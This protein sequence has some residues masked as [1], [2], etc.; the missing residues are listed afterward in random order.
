MGTRNIHKQVFKRLFIG[1]V[2]LSLII[3]GAVAY[4]EIRKADSL[5]LGLA[6]EESRFLTDEINRSS[7]SQMDAL[8]RRVDEFIKGHFVVIELY[9][10]NRNQILREI[11]PRRAAIEQKL[12]QHIR[13][14]PLENAVHY[15]NFFVE[16]RLFLHLL[17]PLHDEKGDLSGYFKGV[18]QVDSQTLHNIKADIAGTLLLVVVVIL[19]TAIMLYP[20]IISLNKGLIKLSSDLLSG[21]IE[22]MDVLGSAIAKRDSDT[23]SHNYRVTIY[24][25]RFA[26]ILGLSSEQI[27]KLIA[28]AFLHDVGKIGIRDNILLKPAGLTDEEFA[29]MRTHVLLGTEII[30]KSKWLVGAREVVEFHHE[31]FDGSGYL[32]GLRGDEIPLN[33]R[34]FTI[35]DVFDA[36]TSRR[37]YK[38]PFSFDDAMKLMQPDSGKRFDPKLFR[39]FGEQSYSLHKEIS[40]ASETVLETM[41]DGLVRKHFFNAK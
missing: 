29:V 4:L 6:M 37:P 32:K 9:D 31:K 14:F 34:I 25:I 35:V 11:N 15:D 8:R 23:N 2:L 30:S 41:L 24:A 5:V 28:G 27:R 17:L 12:E 36:L 18:Y 19:L 16:D 38:E 3:G 20:I 10:E 26:E 13:P 22:L 7:A 40:Q 39:I 33:A 21:N 1:W